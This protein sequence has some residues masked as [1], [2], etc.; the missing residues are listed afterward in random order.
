MLKAYLAHSSMDK[1]YVRTVANRLGRSI[2]IFDEMAFPPGF[3]FRDTIRNYLDKSSVFIFFASKTSIES[4][5]VK[6]E[7]NEADW[8]LSTKQMAGALTILIDEETN[9][10]DLPEWMKRSLIV[11]VQYPQL[12][13]HTIRNFIVQLSITEMQPLFVGR[14]ADLERIS[15]KL[16]PE[17]DSQP[18]RTIVVAGLQGIGRRTFSRRALRDYLLANPGPLFI[19]EDTDTPDVLYVHLLNETT[20]ISNREHYVSLLNNFRLL[21]PSDQGK[22]IARLL[23]GGQATTDPNPLRNLAYIALAFLASKSVEATPI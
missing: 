1:N 5:W 12:A 13:V 18:P 19:L 22:E 3:D 11:R 7:I 15:H 4:T 14:E 20:D 21:S 16:I 9:V 8:S 17:I 6:F 2:T 23:L 10:D